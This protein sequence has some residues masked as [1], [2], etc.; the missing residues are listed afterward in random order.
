[1]VDKRIKITCLNIALVLTLL[2]IMVTGCTTEKSGT[3][4]ELLTVNFNANPLDGNAPQT[5]TFASLCSDDADSYYWDF[6][7]GSG[8]KEKDPVHVYSDEGIYTVILVVNKA[9]GIGVEKK[10]DYITISSNEDEQL[11]NI[12]DWRDAGNYIGQSITVE[13]VIKDTYYALNNSSKPTFLNFNIPY[14]DSFK[15]LIWGSDRSKFVNAF[16]SSPE[17]YLLNKSVQ[18]TG[19]I[20]EYPEGSGIPEMILTEPS[21]ITIVENN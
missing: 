4:A 12:V 16:H 19:V 8:S 11:D 9:G 10:T 21:Q 1:V 17:S 13:G 2:S 15:C 7:D 20:K 3:S 6:G 14:E 5:V 18:V